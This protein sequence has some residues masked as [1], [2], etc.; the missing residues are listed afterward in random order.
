VIAKAFIKGEFAMQTV[1]GDAHE[2]YCASEG[3]KSIASTLAASVAG[4][5]VLVALGKMTTDRPIDRKKLPIPWA[6]APPLA[7]PSAAA[8]PEPR[9]PNLSRDRDGHER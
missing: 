5:A 1:G 9:N 3:L 7:A 6:L 4:R 8:T 2:I